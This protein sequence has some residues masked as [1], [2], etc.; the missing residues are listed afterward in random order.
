MFPFLWVPELFPAS[1]TSFSQQQLT[2]I[3]PQQSNQLNSTQ[4]NSAQLN[5]TQLN[6][7]Q[8][9]SA[10]LKSSSWLTPLTNQTVLLITSRRGSRRKHRLQQFLRCCL[11]K[12]LSDGP[13]TVAYL[14]DCCLAVSASLVRYSSCE[15]ACHNNCCV[16]HCQRGTEDD[17]FDLKLYAYELHGK[18][19]NP[20][21]L[22]SAVNLFVHV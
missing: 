15:A 3:E 13:D 7:A 8:L 18:Q 5:S 2:R 14:R 9:S 20:L 17:V 22:F 12:F 21:A 19:R 4:L 10:Q 1:T 11:H 6:S 16:K